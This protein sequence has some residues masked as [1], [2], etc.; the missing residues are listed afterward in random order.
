MSNSTT[1]VS[2]FTNPVTVGIDLG[3]RKSFMIRMDPFRNIEDQSTLR[4]TPDAFE[5]FFS[6]KAPMRVIFEVST[7][8][9][10]ISSQLIQL[11]HDVLVVDPRRLPRNPCED[12]SD[13]KDAEHLARVGQAMPELFHPVV[14]RSDQAHAD[15]QVVQCR[16]TLV[17]SRT[18]YVNTIRGVVK[19]TGQRLPSCSASSFHR[20][21]V[22]SIPEIV[23]PA[24]IPL[25]K[26]LESLHVAIREMTKVID[27]MAKTRYPE[28]ATMTQVT[29]VANLTAL[30]VMLTIDDK[31]RFPSSRMVGSYFG[32]RP[33][34]K[35][36]STSEPQLRITK[37]GNRFV[38]SHLVTA[39]HYI[40]GPLCKQD[41][42]LRRWGLAYCER[43]GKNAK[44]RAIVAVA[45]K[46]AV[47][48]HRLWVTGEVYE[49][50]RGCHELVL[51]G[52][53]M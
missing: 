17:Q 51:E 42:A 16:H 44:K 39:A 14:H 9:R 32:L 35:E 20:K 10:W 26:Q 25:I 6:D 23:R 1:L 21:V 46:L 29:G 38:R 33:K 18:K 34:L 12:K 48:L 45:R 24:C 4:T 19:A 30:T 47:L 7:H 22:D 52:D 40:L 36:S 13:W 41:S 11:G 50:L 27:E 8:S 5:K 15:L 49:P 2:T 3:D 28:S 37:A 53:A 31:N 43:G